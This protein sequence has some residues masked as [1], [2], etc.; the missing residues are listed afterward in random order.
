MLPHEIVNSLS[1]EIT[2]ESASSCTTEPVALSSPH[3]ANIMVDLKV[4]R[5]F[6][7]ASAYWSDSVQQQVNRTM[8]A[9]SACI[10]D[11]AN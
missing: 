4:N 3:N 6:A 10:S 1:T 2:S 5:L 7:V 11:P 9:F 8:L